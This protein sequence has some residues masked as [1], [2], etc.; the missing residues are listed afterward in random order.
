MAVDDKGRPIIERADLMETLIF[1]TVRSEIM[2]LDV[3]WGELVCVLYV[4]FS[5]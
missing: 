2:Y 5:F 3:R 4:A 1:F